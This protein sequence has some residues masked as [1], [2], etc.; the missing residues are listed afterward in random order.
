MF[1]E[2]EQDKLRLASL[3]PKMNSAIIGYAY[4]TDCITNSMLDFAIPGQYHWQ[5][6]NAVLFDE[7]ICNVSGQVVLWH[8]PENHPAVLQ[9]VKHD[10]NIFYE[11]CI[12]K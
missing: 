12:N 5:F 3:E 6:D 9:M 10:I 2:S 11:L 4:L 1:K 8:L 7:P